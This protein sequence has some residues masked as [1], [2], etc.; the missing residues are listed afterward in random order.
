MQMTFCPEDGERFLN[1]MDVLSK[2]SLKRMDLP[3][4][5]RLGITVQFRF[6]SPAAKTHWV[7]MQM[8]MM[9]LNLKLP[10]MP[11]SIR[12]PGHQSQ[13]MAVLLNLGNI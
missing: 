1:A 12:S 11:D 10:E 5:Q 8:A 6:G 4:D 2:T 7:R 13:K 3:E 9:S